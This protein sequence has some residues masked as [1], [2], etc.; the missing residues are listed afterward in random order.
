MVDRAW[1]PATLLEGR[2]EVGH[3]VHFKTKDDEARGNIVETERR[4]KNHP[5]AVVQ[6][7]AGVSHAVEFENVSPGA[8]Q[9]T[10][11][12]GKKS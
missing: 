8:F 12:K 5:R 10:P 3:R 6:T 2:V 9:K 7:K 11:E 4:G 1:K